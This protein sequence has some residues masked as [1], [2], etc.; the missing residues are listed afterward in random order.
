MRLWP[1]EEA[2]E[3]ALARALGEGE[4]RRLHA[5]D[6]TWDAFIDDVARTAGTRTLEPVAER[7]AL[8]EACARAT[9]GGS[10]ARVAGARGFV[11][12]AARFVTDAE[13]AGLRGAALRHACRQATGDTDATALERLEVLAG[14]LDHFQRLTAAAGA[15]RAGRHAA[16][17][18]WIEDGGALPASLD[19]AQELVV[20][21]RLGWEPADVALVVALAAR[22]GAAHGVVRVELPFAGGKDAV[23]GGLEPVRR[24]IEARAELNALELTSVDLADAAVAGVRE[25]I[26]ALYADATP[27][28]ATGA[29]APLRVISAPNPTAELRALAAHARALVDEGTPPEEI[30]IGARAPEA[31]GDALAEELRRVGLALDDRRGPALATAPVAQLA[32]AILALPER[33]WPRED[34]LA[35]IGSRYV[36]GPVRL[37]ALARAAGLLDLGPTGRARLARAP[38]GGAEVA[39]SLGRRLAP[40]DAL[41][42]SAPL[43]RHVAALAAAMDALGIPARAR[44]YDPGPADDHELQPRVDRALARDQAAMDALDELFGD[45]PRAAAALGL[46]ARPLAR[47]AFAELLADL[48]GQTTLRAIGARGGAVKLVHLRDLAARSFEHVLVPGLVDGAAP[49]RGGDDGVYGERERRA[50]NQLADERVV[51]TTRGEAEGAE[52]TPYEALMLVGALAAARVGVVLS[53]ARVVGGRPAMRSPFLD[54]VCRAAPG[55]RVEVLAPQ[56]VP[57]AE[58]ARAPADLLTR[59]ALEAFADP[60]LRL[61]GVTEPTPTAALYAAVQRGWPARVARVAA[62]ARV[63]RERWRYF[64]MAP[65]A[66]AAPAAAGRFVGGVGRHSAL[67]RRAGGGPEA[68]VG[69]SLLETLANCGFAFFAKKVLG[70]GELDEAGQAPDAREVGTLA[71]RALELFYR[72]RQEAGAPPLAASEEEHRELD[73]ALDKVFAEDAEQKPGHPVLRAIERAR[74]GEQLWRLIEHEATHLDEIGGGVPRYFELEFGK[75]ENPLPALRIGTGDAALHVHGRIDR[76]D[77]VPGGGL[78][79]LD[80]KLGRRDSQSRKLSDD[81]AGVTQ[82][83]LPIYALAARATMAKQGLVAADASVDAA[84]ISLRDGAPTRL[85]S[86]ALKATPLAT[87]LDER[88]PATLDGLAA[89][90]IG[91]DFPVDP[92][93]CAFC[94]YRT[95]CR[96]VALVE[97]DEDAR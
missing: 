62:M 9:A 56:P 1:R 22:A 17:R 73:Q 87:L 7:L 21:P 82:L 96:V 72:A 55:L 29:D 15:S 40:I 74:L 67:A 92:K 66:R 60:A 26:L 8:R 20:G 61:P 93:D 97:E 14:V 90:L 49:A 39:A 54:E 71:H 31:L 81:E 6:L 78:V 57:S 80:Y 86:K 34:V 18:R 91:G 16:A 11:A 44:S 10:W 64:A 41:P 45:L 70:I 47:L 85:L 75:P 76:V 53:H 4:A 13:R 79:V 84:F 58:A 48:M 38:G 63:E 37:P 24:A 19:L 83:Q 27:A 35:V 95:V 88:L 50:L 2:I 89:R 3:E 42:T 77:L 43:A 59:A 94:S 65:S 52:R 28:A 68:P 69:A 30:A 5:R 46:G 51:A 33:G 32:L 23:D 12:A 36:D 25:I